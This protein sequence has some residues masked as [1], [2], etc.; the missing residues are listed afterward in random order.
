MAQDTG[1]SPAIQKKLFGPFNGL[2]NTQSPFLRELPPSPN[3]RP[4]EYATEF[5]NFIQSQDTQELVSRFGVEYIEKGAATAPA[6]SATAGIFKWID[7]DIQTG[8]PRERGINLTV[9]SSGVPTLYAYRFIKTQ[10]RLTDNSL[11]GKKFAIIEDPDNSYAK[12]FMI[13]NSDDSVFASYATLAGVTNTTV[14]YVDYDADRDGSFVLG[15]VDLLAPVTLTF[16]SSN[17]T[18]T[19]VAEF[20]SLAKKT[21][22]N[23]NLDLSSWI[24][25]LNTEDALYWTATQVNNVLMFSGGGV[26]PVLKYD[27]QAI[28]KAGMPHAA[29]HGPLDQDSESVAT[30]EA[31]YGED[32]DAVFE[33]LMNPTAPASIITLG[34]FVW[35]NTYERGDAK[36]N[37]IEGAPY[38]PGSYNY[39]DSL[40][41]PQVGVSIRV[42]SKPVV[43]LAL[44]GGNVSGDVYRYVAN[45]LVAGDGYDARGAL[46]RDTSGTYVQSASTTVT[47][48]LA[49]H[50]R[51]VGE[52]IYVT[53]LTGTTLDGY[54]TVA[55]VPDANTFTYVSG[56][57]LTTSGN[58]KVVKA[59]LTADVAADF[60]VLVDSSNHTLLAGDVVCIRAMLFTDTA[61]SDATYRFPI[62]ITTKL[63]S[64]TSS[65]ITIDQDY[66]IT[67]E[68]VP[69]G[70][71][72]ANALDGLNSVIT[73]DTQQALQTSL[74]VISNW[75]DLAAWDWL[76]LST[77]TKIVF[78]P[79]FCISNNLRIN[80]YRNKA[81][82]NEENAYDPSG[83]DSD[84][85]PPFFL[86]NILP[87]NP[88]SATTDMGAHYDNC[89]D[90][91]LGAELEAKSTI[92]VS[93]Q[94]VENNFTDPN[95]T[96]LPK[97]RF[98][99]SYKSRVYISDD[100]E[101]SNILFR[102]SILY[103]SEYFDVSD[104]LSMETPVGDEV[105]AVVGNDEAIFVLKDNSVKII[106]NDL[107]NN[108]I[109]IDDFTVG[110][111]GCVAPRTAVPLENGV[112]YLTTNGPA[113][114]QVNKEIVYLGENPNGVSRI[115][116]RLN[117]TE[118]DLKRATA[119]VDTN[120]QLYK[121]Y[122]PKITK[123]S[124]GLYNPA[125]NRH[126]DNPYYTDDGVMFVFDYAN[127]A[128]YE[129][130]GIN[131]KGGMI[132]MEQS[133]D[134]RAL[135]LTAYAKNTSES[136]STLEWSL[137][138]DR[139]YSNLWAYAD[140]LERGG[141][142]SLRAIELVYATDWLSMDDANELKKWLRCKVYA[143][144]T[145]DD[146]TVLGSGGVT[147]VEAL[148]ANT[149][150]ITA[151]PNW[152]SDSVHSSADIDLNSLNLYAFIKCRNMHA[153]VM[154]F[155]LTHETL[156]ASPRIQAIEVE[157]TSP[158]KRKMKPW[159][160]P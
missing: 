30:F 159:G 7:Y 54:Y 123:P 121:L 13:Y 86:L 100:P 23:S 83:T 151:Y 75:D 37:F 42:V 38:V 67:V 81:N 71:H 149:I 80:I 65:S 132:F 73:S 20:W 70:D 79:E 55:T 41:A 48:T 77:F 114:I 72:R 126:A 157:A 89:K 136:E 26:C 88:F 138:K 50:G 2:N 45:S 113:W 85:I 68:L 103:G 111:D 142:E 128:W 98:I 58:I 57:S 53:G 91:C 92:L 24:D 116:D 139:N 107:E 145:F 90:Q 22:T 10:L 64:I 6:I 115:K 104:T 44:S 95:Y 122:I 127:D 47:V 17:G 141:T 61:G 1:R 25:T 27:G 51:V 94:G 4:Q 39:V 21:V 3:A 49:G 97:G 109:R 62:L 40:G 108:R 35:I 84:Y 112:A 32:L 148:G 9:D 158:F 66:P 101:N 82:E 56:S 60:T 120:K 74:S 52:R 160:T 134:G 105:K 33:G 63:A 110:D 76:G 140:R 19:T 146:L 156:Y 15:A 152:R 5:L 34:D 133:G 46:H 78:E 106:I 99:S 12:R 43:E 96:T 125:D 8:K 118:L 135:Y 147:E 130:N 119:V 59:F 143:I 14:S 153:S 154:K 124:V 29:I 28:Y 16:S 11:N 144:R 150:T 69:G 36:N 31:T 137:Y 131:A 155:K 129:Q 18:P 117:D 102:S 87:N 93:D